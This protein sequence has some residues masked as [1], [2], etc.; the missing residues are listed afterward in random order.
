MGIADCIAADAAAYVDLAVRLGTDHAFNASIR[1]RILE[2]NHVLY[3]DRRVV[4]EFERFFMMALRERGTP[5][6]LAAAT[7]AGG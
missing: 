5:I 6:G 2:H 4:Q 7:G 3:E 1:A